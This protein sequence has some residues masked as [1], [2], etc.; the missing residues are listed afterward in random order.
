MSTFVPAV[1]VTAVAKFEHKYTGEK[2][3]FLSFQKGDE[4]VLIKEGNTDWWLARSVS[5]QRQGF[6]PIKYF[7]AAPLAPPPLPPA[8]AVAGP[9]PEVPY[10]C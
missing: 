10:M 5:A 4:F 3:N 9:K 6:V 1:G 8:P 7:E 2:P